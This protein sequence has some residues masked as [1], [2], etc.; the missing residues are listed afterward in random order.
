MQQHGGRFSTSQNSP[1]SNSLEKSQKVVLQGGFGSFATPRSFSQGTISGHKNNSF[2]QLPFQS[3]FGSFLVKALGSVWGMRN[4]PPWGSLVT[5]LLGTSPGRCATY[6]I[7]PKR[8]VE[9]IA[10][11]CVM[12]AWQRAGRLQATSW[13]EGI[14]AWRG[15]LPP[16]ESLQK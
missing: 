12:A 8:S 3:D 9:W 7:D 13:V 4:A 1:T 2:L 14:T 11:V 5:H 6:N 10:P 15:S 16:Y